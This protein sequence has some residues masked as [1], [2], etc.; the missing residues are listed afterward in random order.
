MTNPVSR[1]KFL[2]ALSAVAAVPS[3]FA[4]S[5]GVPS[6][7]F[8]TSD[9]SAKTADRIIDVHVH[10]DEKNTNFIADL[11]KLSAD[12]GAV[13]WVPVAATRDDLSTTSGQ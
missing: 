5:A 1:R 2:R 4:F 10:F 11:L 12:N 3:A 9:T 7:G 8:R 13:V 6:P